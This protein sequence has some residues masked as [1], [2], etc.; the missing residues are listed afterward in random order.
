MF[1]SWHIGKKDGALERVAKV[2][3]IQ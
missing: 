1:P 2:A 3:G